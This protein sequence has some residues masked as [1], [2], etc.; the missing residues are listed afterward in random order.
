MSTL[1][2]RD[3]T[4]RTCKRAL[5]RY[6]QSSPVAIGVAEACRKRIPESAARWPAFPKADCQSMNL[7]APGWGRTSTRLLSTAPKAVASPNSATGALPC[8]CAIG[9]S[10]TRMSFRS[11]APQAS[12]S[13]KDF[14]TIAYVRMTG[15][16]PAQAFAHR[17]LNSA[18]LPKIPPHPHIQFSTRPSASGENRTRTSQ[19]SADFR[20]AA[21][22]ISPRWHG[23][24][25]TRIELAR[26]FQPSRA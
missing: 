19:S 5:H 3:P 14:T 8:S 23:V 16:E 21:S 7:S 18:C 24:S 20:S 17:D 2:Q 25:E 9:G 13:T 22:T 11:L 4:G 6:V 12:V 1:P 10:R 15:V 26:A